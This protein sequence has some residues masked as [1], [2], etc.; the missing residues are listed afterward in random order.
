M[1]NEAYRFFYQLC[2]K[3]F[4]YKLYSPEGSRV[5]ACPGISSR[6]EWNNARRSLPWDVPSLIVVSFENIVPT[7]SGKETILF[8]PRETLSRRLSTPLPAKNLV[9]YLGENNNTCNSTAL[10]IAICRRVKIRLEFKG[11][12]SHSDDYG[13]LL[14]KELNLLTY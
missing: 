8:P 5:E 3:E 13:K 7:L 9:E 12:Y 1:H 14:S 10:F 6:Y 11:N 4:H 2:A